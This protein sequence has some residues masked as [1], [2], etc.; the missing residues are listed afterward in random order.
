MKL[1]FLIHLL[2]VDEHWSNSYTRYINQIGLT[3]NNRYLDEVRDVV[4]NFPYKDSILK[5]G[6]TKDD[7]SKGC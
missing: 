4:I 1:F 6:M 7:A 2:K 5:A 3:T